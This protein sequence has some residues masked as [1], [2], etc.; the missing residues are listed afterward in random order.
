MFAK[1]QHVS[2]YTNSKGKHVGGYTRNAT[3]NRKRTPTAPPNRKRNTATNPSPSF[4]L[5]AV[6]PQLINRDGPHAAMYAD[7]NRKHFPPKPT[8]S[9]FTAAE[10]PE[11]ILAQATQQRGSLNGDDRNLITKLHPE[12]PESTFRD[13]CRYLLVKTPGMLGIRNSD[14]VPDD[15]P[16][17]VTYTK[18]GCSPSITFEP[19]SPHSKPTPTYYATII[20]G[21]APTNPKQHV[22]W[23]L[24]PGF[25]TPA[26]E[27]D[28]PREQRMFALLPENPAIGDHA[29]ITAEWAKNNLF[30]GEPFWIQTA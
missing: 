21:P 15:T 26:P 12:L 5:S 1:K 25:P 30:N 27:K 9:W 4:T 20:L 18:T 16:L 6:I 13:D 11:E 29:T 14:T 3:P 23:T 7:L 19:G 28:S 22:L 10:T 24:H 8:G 2:G 17:H